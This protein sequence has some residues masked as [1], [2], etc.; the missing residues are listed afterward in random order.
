MGGNTAAAHFAGY[1]EPMYTPELQMLGEA[2]RLDDIGSGATL[3]LHPNE[4]GFQVEVMPKADPL[5][6]RIAEALPRLDDVGR[7][8]LIRVL[9]LPDDADSRPPPVPP[10]KDAASE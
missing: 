1:R 2:L 4:P 9:G 10:S 8:L 6:A 5:I 3:L 7:K